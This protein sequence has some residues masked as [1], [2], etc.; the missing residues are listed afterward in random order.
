MNI[1]EE[2]WYGNILHVLSLKRPFPGLLL[3]HN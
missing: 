2:F 3:S 1:L